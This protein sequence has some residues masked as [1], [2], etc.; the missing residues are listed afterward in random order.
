MTLND[1]DISGGAEQGINGNTVANFT[2]ADSSISNVG[3][4]VDEDNIH[5]FNMSG[6]SAITNTIL[7]KLIGEDGDSLDLQTQSGNLD[8]IFREAVRLARGVVRF[9]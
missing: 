3:N 2:L 4:E 8:L 1:I 5:F 6:T 9:C 7:T